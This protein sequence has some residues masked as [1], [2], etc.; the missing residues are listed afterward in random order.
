MP[1]SLSSSRS[2]TEPSVN[3]GEQERIACAAAGVVVAGFGIFGRNAATPLLALLGGYLIHRGITGHCAAYEQ[4][5]LDTNA[6]PEPSVPL[7]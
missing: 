7:M 5:G 4:L 6:R 2:I 1:K 3:V